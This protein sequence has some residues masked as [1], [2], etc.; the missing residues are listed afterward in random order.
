MKG[1]NDKEEQNKCNPE[2]FEKIKKLFYI[3]SKFQT[4]KISSS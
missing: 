3:K 1:I 2:Y 4:S